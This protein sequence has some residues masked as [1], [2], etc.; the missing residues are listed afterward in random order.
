MSHFI[1][2]KLTAFLIKEKVNQWQFN[3]LQYLIVYQMHESEI[4]TNKKKLRSFNDLN[5]NNKKNLPGA[6]GSCL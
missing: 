5:N 4:L 1:I 3:I 2:K 6:S